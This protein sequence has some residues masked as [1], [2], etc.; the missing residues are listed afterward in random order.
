MTMRQDGDEEDFE[1]DD[2]FDFDALLREKSMSMIHLD[3]SKRLAQIAE[4]E[5]LAE[6]AEQERLAEIAEK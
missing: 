3:E 6:I 2:R 5:M 4:K 1:D